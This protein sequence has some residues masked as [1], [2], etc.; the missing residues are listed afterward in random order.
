MARR[1][2]SGAEKAS[3]MELDA[4]SVSVVGSFASDTVQ[5]RSGS[6]AWHAAL[7]AVTI[8]D[9]A[10]GRMIP[11][12]T[13]PTTYS[14]FFAF[15]IDPVNGLAVFSANINIFRLR[16]GP[17]D[18]DIVGSFVWLD[19]ASTGTFTVTATDLVTPRT[20]SFSNIRTGFWNL[21]QVRCTIN[22]GV[23]ATDSWSVRLNGVEQAG[24]ATNF[25]TAG[26]SRFDFGVLGQNGVSIAT[27]LDVFFD[28]IILDDASSAFQIPDASFLSFHEADTNPTSTW[29]LVGAANTVLAVTDESDS[30]Y[31]NSL[32]NN[33]TQEYT[34]T[35]ISTSL[36]ASFLTIPCVYLSTRDLQDGAVAGGYT[37]RFV[38]GANLGTSASATSQAAATTKRS[39]RAD[40]NPPSGAAW[41][42]ALVNNTNERFVSVISLGQGVRITET[43]VYAEVQVKI[44]LDDPAAL[45]D[46]IVSINA[47]VSLN[48]ALALAEALAIAA[49][50]SVADNLTLADVVASIKVKLTVD[51][52]LTA[53]DSAD[54]LIY[55]PGGGSTIR[56]V[57]GV[58]D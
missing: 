12:G 50:V 52:A 37:A 6:R 20:L 5:A 27:D 4:T 8:L 22:T 33:Q 40:P 3:T 23:G 32:T 39:L 44:N 29:G 9:N 42:S 30:S 28:D 13:A 31:I 2:C 19:G 48:D 56:P 43:W 16:H 45:T 54:K 15:W 55:L 36:P 7:L 47:D 18:G 17:A 41:T 24:T 53:T 1:D 35:N 49:D 51:D 38:E 14:K 34:L 26:L 46:A 57:F 10:E 25:A 58:F 21:C 11:P